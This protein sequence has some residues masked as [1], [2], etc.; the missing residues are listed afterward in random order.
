M[1]KVSLHVVTHPFQSLAEVVNSSAPGTQ[2]HSIL[3][4]L[5]SQFSLLPSPP[6]L[7]FRL[8]LLLLLLHLSS[9]ESLL[10]H[11]KI[12]IRQVC[13]C[14]QVSWPTNIVGY[15]DQLPNTEPDLHS[16]IKPYLAMMY[17]SLAILLNSIC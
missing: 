1:R 5:E 9:I 2:K 17:N 8:F 13:G 16:W 3:L 15:V 10:Y 11:C 4:T 7:F 12:S 14:I 6:P